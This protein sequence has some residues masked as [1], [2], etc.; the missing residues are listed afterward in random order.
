MLEH[1]IFNSE[2]ITKIE[3]L[4]SLSTGFYRYRPEK[5]FL[6]F[7]T[8]RAGFYNL[9]DQEVSKEQLTN[10]EL[11]RQYIVD[12]NNN[13]MSKPA[14]T[15]WFIDRNQM[16]IEFE[17]YKQATEYAEEIK[18]MFLKHSIEIKRDKSA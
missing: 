7:T 6:G 18:K 12:E 15:I 5:K 3:I 17:T 14:V 10:G 11:G 16:G 13:V 9:L 8:S 4:P 1:K 2:A